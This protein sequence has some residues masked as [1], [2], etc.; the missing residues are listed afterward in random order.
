MNLIFKVCFF[1]N[2][3]WKMLNKIIYMTSTVLQYNFEVVEY[4][5]SYSTIII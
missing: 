5:V 1:L 3:F 2:V 4:Y